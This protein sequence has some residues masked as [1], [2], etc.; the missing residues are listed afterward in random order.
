MEKSKPAR[1]RCLFGIA[2]LLVGVP[3][4]ASFWDELLSSERDWR[5]II[6][7]NKPDPLTVLRDNDPARPNADGVRR[8]QALAQLGAMA[9][10]STPE[11]RSE[12]LDKL[13]NA[14]Q[15]DPSPLCRLTA[16]RGLGK[17]ADARAAEKLEAVF[18]QQKLPFTAENNYM[19]RREA[20]VGLEQL[21]DP[22]S[23]RLMIEVARQPGPPGKANHVDKTQTQ[24]EKIVAIRALGKYRDQE[25]IDALTS[26]LKSEKDIALRHRARQSL[27]EA[28]GKHW[29][30]ALEEWQKA[31]V[32]PLPPESSTTEAIRLMKGWLP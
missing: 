19:I 18:R 3:G 27:D 11:Q 2:C 1:W 14:A 31:E 8:A 12:Y 21:H 22:S 25:A 7:Y 30:D 26:V 5:Y 9:G 32:Q 20:L 6:G 10:S 15:T 16:I 17:F 29:P 28:T 23:L 24:D 4:C 13:A